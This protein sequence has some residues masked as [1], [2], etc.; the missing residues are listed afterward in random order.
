MRYGIFSDVHGNLEAFSEAIIRFRALK[1]DRYIFLGD[2]VG[3]GANPKETISLLKEI[4]SINVAGNHDWACVDK[5]DI[6]YFNDYAK[7]A[8][9]WTKS[10]L[11]E[12]D[13][14]FLLSLSLVYEEGDFVC[15]HGNLWQP[16]EFRYVTNYDDA[17]LLFSILRK[18][19]CFIGHSHRMEGYVLKRGEIRRLQQK[20]VSLDKENRYIFNVGSVG[21]P[22]DGKSMGCICVYD[23]KE[24]LVTFVRFGYDINEASNKIIKA[25]LPSFLG[26]RLYLGK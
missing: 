22:R 6:K 24:Q 17:K 9:L 13:R 18:H 23:S 10:V 12:E 26:Q 4:R 19:I 5:F 20:E 1:I 3:Y 15:V 7:E 16:H 14:S 25:G 21:Q 8:I 11:G 2:I